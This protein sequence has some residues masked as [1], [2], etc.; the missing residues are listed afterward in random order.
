MGIGTTNPQKPL[1][2]NGSARVDGGVLADEICDE[3][4]YSCFDPELIVGNRPEMQCDSASAFYG[5]QP[6][7]KVGEGRV[8]CALPANNIG[9]P[10][11]DPKDKPIKLPPSFAARDCFDS[12]QLVSGF[13]AGG[14][15]VCITP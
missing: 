2:V 14:A 8:R 13:D 10:I 4:Y 6:V 1:A 12:G 15:P 5:D 3:N 9:G 11:V 7:V